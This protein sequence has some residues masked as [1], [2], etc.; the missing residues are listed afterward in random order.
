MD[1]LVATLEPAGGQAPGSRTLITASSNS[2]PS[3][4]V[5]ASR[6]PSDEGSLAG[7][8]TVA[9]FHL[10]GVTGPAKSLPPRLAA[11]V[12]RGGSL[13]ALTPGEGSVARLYA[14]MASVRTLDYAP[15]TVPRTPRAAARAG[16][17]MLREVRL[18]RRELRRAR[19]DLV[20]VVTS[21]LP[22]ALIAARL[23][24][25]PT[26]VYVGELF[27]KGH[28]EG[29]A[30]AL[31][32][33]LLAR[34]CE[35]LA[36]RLVCCSQAVADQ[37]RRRDK[38]VAIYPGI[39]VEHADGERDAFRARQ[40]VERASPL[41]AVVGNVCEARGQ[42]TAVRAL[43]AVRRR[44]P[45]AR[46]L[47]AGVPALPVDQAYAERLRELSRELGVASE[48]VFSGFVDRVGD[49]YAAADAV[50]NPAH[51][52]EPFGRVAFEA[53]V[54]GRPV[55]A[56]A[57]GAIPEVLRDG[58]D[59]LLVPPD[60]PEALGEAVVRLTED[61]DLRDRLV[62]EG[63]ARARTDFGE[64]RGVELWERVVEEALARRG[65]RRRTRAPGSGGGAEVD[66]VGHAPP[67]GL[68]P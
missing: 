40:G 51:F 24:R 68:T 17:S 62:A 10:A 15:L 34:V 43:A 59:A 4:T 42:D 9:I 21:A 47:I 57:V 35:T 49:V 53:L 12:A 27:A 56:S 18:F 13:E 66:S 54:A 32:G 5:P 7:L 44:L 55:V 46:L 11:L 41:L 60:D 36:D 3:G 38:A 22:A 23:E 67:E 39:G 2:P 33:R 30:R 20:V 28:V 6:P 37:F 58:R 52:N 31:A 48:V 1:M 65:R 50:I 14:G 16:W 61:G 45:D 64:E 8:R 63:G 26:V 29:A 25:L 19:P